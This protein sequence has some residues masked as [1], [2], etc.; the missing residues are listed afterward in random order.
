MNTNKVAEL[1]GFIER[2]ENE[3][4]LYTLQKKP[5][6]I[7]PYEYGKAIDDFISYF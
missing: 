3:K 2:F 5:F 7:M 4:P 6:T 1:T